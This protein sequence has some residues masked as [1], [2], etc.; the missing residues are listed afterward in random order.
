MIELPKLGKIYQAG[1]ESCGKNN[2]Q[3]SVDL[4]KNSHKNL[5]GAMAA[6]KLRLLK[7]RLLGLLKVFF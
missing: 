2:C 3:Y 6:G 7:A 5:F 1:D 4:L